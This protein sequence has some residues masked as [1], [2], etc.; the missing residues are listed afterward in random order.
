ML[1]LANNKH[2]INK[3]M[4]QNS[5]LCDESSY[6]YLHKFDVKETCYTKQRIHSHSNKKRGIVILYSPL[7]S[8]LAKRI[9]G[10]IRKTMYHESRSRIFARFQVLL[11]KKHSVY[12]AAFDLRRTI[13]ARFCYVN[14]FTM[15]PGQNFIRAQRTSFIM[16]RKLG[17][18]C[19]HRER[20]MVEKTRFSYFQMCI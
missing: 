20:N 17:R 16:H 18:Q 12:V 14:A 4:S 13:Y 11:E 2:T 1:S 15:Y 6:C 19:E 5:Y 8:D 7:S 9:V 10:R 3:Y